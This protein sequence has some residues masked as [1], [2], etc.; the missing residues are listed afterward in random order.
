[1][2]A[3]DSSCTLDSRRIPQLDTMVDGGSVLVHAVQFTSVSFL[4][5][6]YAIGPILV[7][8]FVRVIIRTLRVQAD[9]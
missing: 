9:R 6:R 5:S 1:M 2:G 4:Y 8:V 3:S 7:V